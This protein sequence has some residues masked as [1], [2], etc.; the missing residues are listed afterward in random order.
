MTT[1]GPE[2]CEYFARRYR[3]GVLVREYCNVTG[4]ECLI[5]GPIPN[6]RLCTRREWL[7]LDAQ[8]QED[9]RLKTAP[10]AAKPSESAT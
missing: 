4:H 3:K 9:R 10:E 8:R 5:D 1:I 2:Y 7:V 6:R